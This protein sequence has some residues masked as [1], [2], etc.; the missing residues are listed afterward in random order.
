MNKKK[1]AII[2]LSSIVALLILVAVGYKTYDWYIWRAPSYN[3]TKKEVLLSSKVD[4]LSDQ[5]EEAFW[6]YARG[7]IES[8]LN[9]STDNLEDDTLY[10]EKTDKKH[11][12]HVEYVCKGEILGTTFKYR[13]KVD[14]T[15]KSSLKESKFKYNNF[16]SDLTSLSSNDDDS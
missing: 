3:S 11:V 10:V 13:T 12:Y 16:Q 1:I 6:G 5:Q 2:S 15:P 7:A 14:I 4:K 9:I 8:D